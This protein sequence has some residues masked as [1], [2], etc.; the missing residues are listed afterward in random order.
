MKFLDTLIYIF[1][2]SLHAFKLNEELRES[3]EE[4]YSEKYQTLIKIPG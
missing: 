1:A 2:S 4:K 3:L